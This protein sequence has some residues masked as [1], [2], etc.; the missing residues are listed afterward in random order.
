MGDLYKC[1]RSQNTLAKAWSHVRSNGKNSSSQDTINQIV[2]F[3]EDSLRE[4]TN[5]QRQLREK[6]F[7]FDQQK[8]IP[9][10]KKKGSSKRRPLVLAPIKNRIVQRAL[11][12]VLQD[13]VPA[14]RSVMATRTS[15][16]GIPKRGT[17]HAIKLVLDAIDDGKHWF[18]SSDIAS[19]FT[20]IPKSEIV[21]FVQLNTGDHDFA[22]L[23]GDAVQ[24]SL[25]N[26]KEL[27]E[28]RDL[29]PIDDEG[30]AQGSPLSPLMGN[31]LLK[32]FDDKLN[33]RGIVCVRYIDDFIILGPTREKVVKAMKAA[34]A[35]LKIYGMDVYDPVTDPVK[36]SFGEVKHGFEFLGCKIN[37]GQ[38]APSGGARDKLYEKIDNVL[39]LGKKNVHAALKSFEPEKHRQCQIQTL[40]RLDGIVRGWGHAFSFCNTPHVF[41]SIDK[42][43]DPKVQGFMRL[44]DSLGK[45][46]SATDR[47]RIL[48]VSLL[49]DVPKKT[50]V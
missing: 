41:E 15:I 30:V 33:D 37:P 27:G 36:A 3:D 19:F 35:M 29:F 28:H 24:V 10:K 13:E 45:G 8:G 5:I 50:L 14:V 26:E 44:C 23:F 43:I 7:R 40:I 49:N 48:G 34:K 31:I 1:V 9:I 18:A 25:A 16:G 2:K 17:S 47:R 46:K 22:K 21:D 20:K 38:V 32:D 6:R 11:L 39:A 12:D 42:R 4:L